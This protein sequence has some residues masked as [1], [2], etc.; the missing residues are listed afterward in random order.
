MA[1]LTVSASRER[2]SIPAAAHSRI[3]LGLSELGRNF[4]LLLDSA[5]SEP[6][7]RRA[8]DLSEVLA[9]ACEFHGLQTLTRLLRVAGHLAQL[10]R[11]QALPLQAALRAKIESLLREMSKALPRRTLRIPG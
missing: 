10:P 3:A 2:R 11:A 4:R 6:L 9:E 5:W 1:G 7:R 8:E